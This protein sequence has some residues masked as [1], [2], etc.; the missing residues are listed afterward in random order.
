MAPAALALPALFPPGD[1]GHHTWPAPNYVNPE[2]RDWKAPACIIALYVAT[3]FIFAARIWAR[4]R[5]TRTPGIDD[6]LI[7]A[8]MPTL[9][10]L[11][12]ATVLALRQYGFQLHIYDQT[13]TTFITVRQITLAMEVI[14]LASTTLT[15]LS[16][17]M[18]YRRITSSVISRPLLIA[19]WA[20]IIFVAAYGITFILVLIFT[21]DPVEAY[22]YRFT[23]SWLRTH[24]YKCTD[25]LATLMVIITISTA[26][27][28][29]ATLLPMFVVH[30]LRLPIRQKIALAAVFLVGLAVCAT[31][32]LRIHFAHRVY[33]YTKINPS[34]TYDIT[35]EALGSWVSTA[36]EA[37]VAVWC[38][39]APA[40]KTFF[41]KW[42]NAPGQDMRS[43]RWYGKLSSGWWRPRQPGDLPDSGLGMSPSPVQQISDSTTLVIS[44]RSIDEALPV[45]SNSLVPAKAAAS[46]PAIERLDSGGTLV[47]LES[48]HA[49]RPG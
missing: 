23:T 31:G 47:V 43:F 14:Y 27:D 35:W 9:A 38:A 11:T 34:P 18:F 42:L 8:T 24:K 3:L 21:C 41:N 39:C 20:S 37:N 30:K 48:N 46:T 13:P 12:V 15:K 45:R 6:W 29:I 4:F 49:T 44:G 40:L 32:A 7:I 17:L 2:T 28:F 10:G 22:W 19:V 5:I 36:V 25:E 33:Y 1:G 26:Q 16:I